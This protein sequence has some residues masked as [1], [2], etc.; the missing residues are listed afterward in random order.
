MPGPPAPLTNGAEVTARP[1]LAQSWVG[2]DLIWTL[3]PR[4]RWAGPERSAVKNEQFRHSRPHQNVH[5]ALE[6]GVRASLNEFD[7]RGRG[8]IGRRACL[9]C[10]YP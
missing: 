10:M 9:R 5:N 2:L 3:R 1:R 7:E 6:V 4:P 8:G